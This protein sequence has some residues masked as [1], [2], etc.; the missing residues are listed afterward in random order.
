MRTPSWWN[1]IK[2]INY[3]DT[4][5]LIIWAAIYLSFLLLDIFFPNFWG[6]A[7]LKYLGIFLC[8]VYANQKFKKDYALELALLF[9]FL[10][11]TILVWTPYTLAGVY[12]FSF[13]QFMHLTRLTK[14]SQSALGIYALALSIFFALTITQGLSPII[15][16]ATIYG[17]ELICNIVMSAKRY[18]NGNKHFR[19]RCALYGFICFFC[20]DLCVALRFLSINQILPAAIIPLTSFLVWVFYYPSQIM[21]ANSST[22][23]PTTR[24][25][26]AKTKHIR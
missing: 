23:E 22:M 14:L 7:L 26:F 21:I 10:A 1:D 13:A 6:S 17:L 25:K 16:A 20:C 4:R 8:I 9:T 15:A 24:S 5:W 3:I 19:A 12:V 2:R 18:R 11:D